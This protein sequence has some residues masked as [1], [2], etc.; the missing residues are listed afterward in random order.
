MGCSS[1]SVP[2]NSGGL[3]GHSEAQ[4][5]LTGYAS[6]SVSESVVERVFNYIKNQMTH[7]QKKSFQ[8]KYDELMKR[9]YFEGV[10]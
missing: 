6:F 8:E 4:L 9:Q 3:N 7:H 1:H 2:S 10:I 5:L